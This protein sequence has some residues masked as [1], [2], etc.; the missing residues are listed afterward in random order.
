MHGEDVFPTA[1]LRTA[2][3]IEEKGDYKKYIT[4]KQKVKAWNNWL[5][6]FISN[7]TTKANELIE[8][9]FDYNFKIKLELKQKQF[10]VQEEEFTFYNHKILFSLTKYDDINNPKIKKPHTFLNEAKWSAIGLSLRFAILDYKLYD[11]DLKA[12][13]I[14]DMLLSL[15]MRNRNIVLNLLLGKYSDDYQLVLMTHDK[16]F[17]ELAKSKIRF[18]SK[19][20]I[21]NF[22]EMYQDDTGDFSKPYFKPFPN[23]IQTAQDFLIQH[24]YAACGI[25]LRKEIERKLGELLPVKLKKEEK[26]VDGET[27]LFDKNLNDFIHAFK[28]FCT[29]ENVDFTPFTDLKTYKDLLLNPLA[30]NDVDAPFFR[31]E[32]N[33]LIKITKDLNNLK[34][35]RLFHRSKKNMNFVLNKPDGTYFSV[36]MKSAEQIVLLE[37]DGQPE[38]ISIYS[39][40]KVSGTD[41][42]GVRTNDIE[43]FDT[44]KDCYIE[45]CTRFGIE[46]SND[47]SNVFDYNGLNFN[48]KLIEINGE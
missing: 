39:K 11:A 3:S 7:I 34:R 14:D 29:E 21:W 33:S 48:D 31:D 10:E 25:Y 47:L 4:Y 27:K 42:N 43:Q 13:V 28:I 44:I 19:T 12:L 41:N 1:S 36:R 24:D 5:K 46:P 9:E 15:D 23:N 30:H 45:M 20:N 17:Y 22:I 35:G 18:N 6:S 8:D 38:R 37:I 2:L 16:S 32:L 26:T 40:C